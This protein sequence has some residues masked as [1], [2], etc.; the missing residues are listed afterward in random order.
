MRRRCVT[1]SA[2]TTLP[3]SACAKCST[4]GSC[5]CGGCILPARWRRSPPAPCNCS[6]FC[7]RPARITTSRGRARICTH[8]DRRMRS[9]DV[10]IVGGGPAGSSAAWRLRR[11]GADVLVLDR[12]RFPRLKLCAGWITP[13][14]VRDLEIDLE[15]YPHRLLTFP[16]LRVHWGRLQVPIPCVQH[17]IR[18]FEFEDRKSTRL[19]SSHTVISYAVFCLKKK[20][21][22]K[23]ALHS[24][25]EAYM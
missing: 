1:G 10:L 17:S 6:R 24:E 3:A 19:N 9:C 4:T 15:A 11:A 8:A 13:E 2:S 5:A 16:R 12:E 22:K 14:V 21:T 25:N 7:L 18:R 23:Q 20:K